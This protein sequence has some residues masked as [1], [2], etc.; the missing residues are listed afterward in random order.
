M[1]DTETKRKID[2]A[3]DI[4]V[5]KIPDPKS[6]IE[7]ITT[8]LIYK[9]M[10]DMDH[11]AVELGGK[12][13]FFAGD[14]A[15]Y[16]WKSLMKLSGQD[17]LNLYTEAIENMKYNPNL[18]PFFRDIFK[19]SFLP[20]RDPK[21]LNLFL[22]Q[23]DEFEYDHSERLGDAF[24]YL[25]SVMG[26]QGDAGQFRTPRH[27]IDFIVSAVDPDKND[28]ILDPAC[29][30][31]GFLISAYKHILEKYTD[32]HPGDKLTPDDRNKLVKNFTGYDIAPEMVRLASVNM[33]LHKFT[34]PQIYEYDSLSMEEKWDDMFDVVLA[35]PPFMTPKGGITPH[36]R[37][38]IKS[39]RAEVLFVDYIMQHLSKD[40]RA[41]VIVPEGIIFQSANAY[42]SLRKK[43]IE[44]HYLWAVVSLPSGVFNPYS[45]V[46]TSI[47]L[48][49][50]QLAKKTDEIIFVK[51]END[52]Y[53][54]GAQRRKV[55]KNDLPKA[56]KVL[57]EYRDWC[58]SHESGNPGKWIPD[59]TQVRGKQVGDDIANTV[60]KS[61]VAEDGEYNLS[62][63]RYKE[64]VVY[65]GEWPMVELGEVVE[66]LD[67]QRVPIKKADRKSGSYPYYGA[68]GI[69]DYVDNYI[70][71]ERLVLV[72][73]DGAKWGVDEN[74]SFIA[75]GKYWVN[76]HAHVLRVKKDRVVDTFLMYMLNHM[77]LTPYITGVT[78]P[79]L[80]QAKLRSIQ[81]PLPPLS[82]QE[83]IVAELDGYSAII[84]GAKQIAQNWKP[85]IDID[86]EWEKVKLGEVCEVNPKKT[87][88]QDLPEDL[89]VSFVPMSDVNEHQIN[90]IPKED[91]PLSAVYK[92][93][94]YFKEN[95]VLLA[96]VTPCFENGKS[97]IA[98]GLT[99]EI[100]FGSSEYYVL[101]AKDGVLL[102]E[103]IY[104]AI[105]S[106]SFIRQG[107]SHMTGTGGLKRLT[108]EFLNS[109]ELPI[110]TISIQEEI[111]KEI[112]AEQEL[113]DGN[114]KLIEI[115]EKKIKEKLDEV[116][117]KEER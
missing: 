7:Q 114:K 48:F 56:L 70:F 101:R 66:V 111:V 27:L 71:D 13:T 116:W 95:D 64:A 12:A 23:I 103:W 65:D 102:P 112:E 2:S 109:Y 106:W 62:G 52:G 100:G 96:R 60:S 31:A 108:K 42:K 72:G 115:F 57:N 14:Y 92:S 54:L 33:Y 58:H 80:N 78:V 67:N 25:L 43:M 90:F 99:N 94:T 26:S 53:D 16:S 51:V 4:L 41:G 75:E 59:P 35:N 74:T 21:V 61:Q 113:V 28:R 9:F 98:R 117:G 83:E 77:D 11:E 69:L 5:G 49:D 63:D 97:G 32:N 34:K 39:N 82:V 50:K 17:K 105:S 20:F 86:T 88:V 87:E 76:N 68:T 1:L 79:K 104:Y 107:Q 45:G 93:Y 30:T 37:F 19:D 55:D 85:K 6:Q 38:S 40:G 8:A 91:R 29:G 47:L 44:D 3:R 36:K 10:D 73:E 89:N 15:K 110:P 22:K 46:K 24:E 84:A 18:E 81:I